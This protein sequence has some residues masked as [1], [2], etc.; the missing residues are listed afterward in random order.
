MIFKIPTLFSSATIHATVRC[1]FI[2]FRFRIEFRM[3]TRHFFFGLSIV[4]VKSKQCV[5]ECETRQCKMPAPF[6][7]QFIFHALRIFQRI[8]HGSDDFE[9]FFLFLISFLFFYFVWKHKYVQHTVAAVLHSGF[10][11]V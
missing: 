1:S 10:V 9:F 11:R 4:N 8:F 2:N 6:C 7:C 3:G 5:T